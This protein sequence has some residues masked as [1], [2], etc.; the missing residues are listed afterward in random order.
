[1]D[2]KNRPE[3]REKH[4]TNNS[5]GV[6]KRG[7][8]LGTGPVGSS[9]GYSGKNSGKG[10]GGGKR[11]MGGG[12]I[13][14]I[15]AI[16]AFKFLFG[17]GGSGSESASTTTQSQSQ[18]STTSAVGN[19]L[20]SVLG[21]AAG[22]TSQAASAYGSSS[23]S[24]SVN[25]SYSKLD[26]SVA[27]GSRAKYTS[28]A[29]NGSDKVTM[30]VYMCGTDLESKNGMASSDLSEMANADF[31]DNVNVIVYTGGCKS[32]RTSGISNTSNQIYQVKKGGI[33]RLVDND[34][35]K[36]MT[37]PATLSVF[38]KW[39]AKNYPANRYELV[40]WDH[41]GGSVS[42]Y[43]YDEKFASKGSMDLSG[44]NK[45]LK[46]G[47][48]KFDFVGFDACL[49]ATAE[50]ALMLND[51][52]DYMIA[53][54]ET[55][56]GIGWFYTNWLTEL[57]KDTSISTLQ[58]GK[59]II[60]DF[61]E[62][63]NK[64][65]P[66]QQ[67]TLSII[68]LAEFANTV[69][70]PLASFSKSISNLISK[71]EYQT[72]SDARYGTR[73][74]ATSSRIDQVDLVDLCQ[75][76]GTSEGTALSKALKGAVKYNRTSSN[77]TNAYGVS[78]YFPYQRA[79]YVDK[80]SNTYEAIGMDDSYLKCIREFANLEVSGQVAAGGSA[81]PLGSLL[82]AFVGDGSS[83]NSSA[84]AIGSLLGAF[85]GGGSSGLIDGLTG[86]NTSFM[87]DRALSV[88]DTAQYI[89]MNR[90]DPNNL[91]WKE[92]KDGKALMTLP[93]SQWSLVHALDLNMFYDDG[94]GY[95]D[96]G[97]DNIFS[98]GENGELVADTDRN[99]LAINGQPV[100]YYHMD[101]TEINGET[102]TTGRV[103]AMLN[104]DRVNLWIV[105]DSS[106]PHGYI[107]GAQSDY[108]EKATQTVAK[109]MTELKVGDTLE[110]LCDYY[111][112]KGEYQDSYYLGE[113]MKVTSK[114]EI[115][116]VDVGTGAVKLMYRFTDIYNQEYW[117]EA[118]VR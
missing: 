46:A 21:G 118:L 116:N 63:C 30:M 101:T 49:M 81:S 43:G 115:S 107:A 28:I 78:I 60:D 32:W 65:C 91:T 97:L 93:E 96:L 89:S 66:G 76:M 41:G 75:K 85:L 50:T 10:G 36:P 90:F 11:A 113:P 86:R 94:T 42:G 114:M 117:S 57:G 87:N 77:M 54:E 73:E 95:V 52:A 67:T 111:S 83:S 105:F 19:I 1:M 22:G 79:S 47:G 26:T 9:N 25:A 6:H 108:Q 4:V 71:K 68:D 27:Q 64:R 59:R 56:P 12:S 29:G 40:F 39:A 53:S 2:Q 106:H 37:D 51:Y 35:A 44:I 100:A 72:V 82:G 34:G 55:E 112:Y 102:V 99:W 13:L 103:P 104:K 8:G 38:I 110:F 3:G 5:S 23:N 80:V 45:A 61:V 31:G 62:Q 20:G 92:S 70:S 109:N 84:D 74:F 16:L 58:I 33:S 15:V 88:D 14:V 48:V 7:D 98:W 24:S 17:G 18:S 69:P